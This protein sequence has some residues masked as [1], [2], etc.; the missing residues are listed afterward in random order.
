MVKTTGD[1]ETPN[2]VIRYASPPSSKKSSAKQ[3]AP[4]Q[5]PLPSSPSSPKAEDPW[6]RV[7]MTETEWKEHRAR[8]QTYL[9][10]W[11]RQDQMNAEADE[12]TTPRFWEQRLE[13]LEMLREKYNKMRAWSSD[14]LRDVERLD[15]A[16]D[17]C[18]Y[19]LNCMYEEMDRLEN[20]YD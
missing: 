11:H 1:M 6:V 8:V 14:V 12:W 18:E 13:I 20:L 16:I 3:R 7:G 19:E 10:E 17:E 15:E 5:E 2:I 9:E 4:F